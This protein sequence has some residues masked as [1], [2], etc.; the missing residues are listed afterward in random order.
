M[1]RFIF[2]IL[3]FL[4]LV[5]PV[6]ALAAGGGGSSIVIVADTRWTSGIS[7]WW[8][9]LYNESH[10]YFTLVTIIIIPVV[11]VIFGTI[12]DFIMAHIG[13]DLT[14]RGHGGH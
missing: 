9:T 3:A 5:L 7:H 4:F 14:K 10:L 1:R 6:T 11:G 13:I 12:A 2:P 8:A